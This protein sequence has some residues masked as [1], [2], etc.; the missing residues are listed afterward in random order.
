MVQKEAAIVYFRE[1]LVICL[2]GLQKK[3]NYRRHDY[4]AQGMYGKN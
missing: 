3:T 4:Q 2:K 1:I